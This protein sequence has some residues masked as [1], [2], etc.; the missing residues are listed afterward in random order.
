MSTEAR[1]AF[2][3][4]NWAKYNEALVNRGDITFWFSDEIIAQWKH[5]NE[6]QGQGRPFTYSDLAIETLLTMR[7]MFRLPYRGTEGFGRWVFRLMKL[8]LAIPDY[9]SLCKRA[10]KL[11]INISIRKAKGK[12]D[13]IV[14]S[15]GLKVFG[16]GEWKVKKHGWAKH[17]TWCKLHLAIDAETQEIVADILT[18]NSVHDSEP[19]APMLKQTRNKVGRFYGDGAYD[20]WKVRNELEN[21]G[22]EQVIPPR[23]DA[24]IKRHGNSKLPRLERDDAIRDIRKYG[25]KG[26]KQRIGYHRRSL[27]ETAMFR[28]KTCFG[29]HLINRL[30]PNQKT[31]AKIRCKILNH[32]TKLGL[33]EYFSKN[34]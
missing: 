34:H 27:A 1:T 28:M 17:R 26:W 16:E 13:I 21:R 3:I 11:D 20:P 19:V 5:D 29:A 6:N 18:D 25:R 10:K 8:D 23:K 12:I 31:E 14:D 7:E 4:R 24:K 33:P 9:T 15:T 30:L 22:I 32:F 2:E